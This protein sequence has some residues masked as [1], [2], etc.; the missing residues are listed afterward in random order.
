MRRHGLIA[1]ALGVIVLAGACSSS[2]PSSGGGSTTGKKGAVAPA[3]LNMAFNADMQVPDPDIFYEVEGNAVMTSVYE[4]LIRYAAN[5]TTFEPA[6]AESYTTSTD[7]LTYTFKLR[8]GV[9]FHDGTTMT[10]N[11]AKV[12]FTRRTAL[13]SVSAPG[14]MLADVAGYDTPDPLTF[15]IRLKEPVSAFLDY[16]ASPYGP[17]VSSSATLSAHAGSD[18]A[19]SWLKTHDA[20][21]GPYTMS[22]FIPGDH[23]T[24]M[25]APNYWGPKPVVTEVHIVIL[26]DITTQ[27][28]ELRNGQLQL[29]M[30]GLS[31]NDVASYDNDSKHQIQRFPANFK[32]MLMVNDNKGVFK[33]QDLRTALQSAINRQQIVSSVFG[34]VNAQIST[35]MYPAGELQAGLA[36]DT[37]AYNPSLLAAAVKGLS[38]KKVDVGYTTDDPRN[39]QAAEIVQT[40]LQAAGLDATVRGITLAVTF[41]LPNHPDQAPDVLMT[42]QNPDASHP[43]NW[44]RIF[45]NTAGALNWLQCSVPAADAE[46]DLGLHSTTPTDVQ[47]HYGKAGDL[48]QKAGCFDNIA[49][50][51]EVLVAQAGY[52][53]WVHQLSALFTV[54]FASLKLS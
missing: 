31:K 34:D 33:S 45:E 25:A 41:D 5:S 1:V 32:A 39:Q 51:K 2:S 20:G 40:E 22:E 35:Q 48:L 6:L 26:P 21:T 12:S 30:H 8:S 47:A 19:Q 14:Y 54:R 46:M 15:V 16:L 11:D 37:P 18:M 36:V 42:T 9:M 27:Q 44:A 53:G 24:L 38:N 13:G 43:D 29:I 49:D 4:G 28:L 17:K 23:Y 7:G 52:T 3:V 10:A 50:V